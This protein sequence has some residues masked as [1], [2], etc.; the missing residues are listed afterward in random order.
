MSVH[1]PPSALENLPNNEDRESASSGSEVEDEE[2]NNFDD[3]VS[4]SVEEQP[5]VSLFD[6]K[7]LSSVSEA[8]KYDKEVHGFD[9]DLVCSNLSLD[10]HQRIR[11]INYI[12]KQK[13]SA[14]EVSNLKGDEAFFASDEYLLPALEDDPLLQVQND[15]WSDEEGP[16]V[17]QP[18]DLKTA[19]RRIKALENE[20]SR[21]KQDLSDYRALVSRQVDLARLVDE[22][23]DAAGPSSQPVP[24]D[25]DSHY[26]ESYGENDIHAV[27]IQDKVRTATYASFIMGSPALFKDAVVLDVGCGTGILSLFAARAGAKRVFAVDASKIANKA[28]QIVKDNG[29][30]DVITVIQGKIEDISLPEGI[31]KV[32]VIVSE[33]MGYALLYESMLDSVLTARDRFLRPEGVLAPSQCQMMLSLCDAKEIYKERIKF[34]SDVYGFDLSAMSED[35]YHDAVMDVVGPE[36]LVSEPYLIK[37]LHLGSVSPRQLSFTSSFTLVSTSDRRTKVHAFILYFDTFFTLTGQP[38]PEGTEV[39]I[40]NQGDAI[41]AEVWPVG[42]LPGRAPKPVRRESQGEGL[43]KE[44]ITSFSTGPRSEPTHWKQTLFFLREPIVVEEGTVVSGTF[45]C[46]KSE[47]NSRELDVEIHYTVKNEGD[48]EPG[49]VVVQMFKVR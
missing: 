38:I 25:D 3:W 41:L 44:K 32:D 5:C 7:T 11:L 49:D 36:T 30:E 17:A 20:L 42:A 35:V 47:G 8:L 24:R 40:V 2:D 1:L 15:D 21:A 19:I 18:E 33:W 45:H 43:K 22:L 13:P 28:R 46:R 10:F 26:F 27:M 14:A 29:Y 37:D 16:S 4:E 39:H 23:G 9:L 48:K 12:R 6:E 34:W 31:E